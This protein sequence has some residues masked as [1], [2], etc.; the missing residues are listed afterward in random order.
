MRFNVGRF[1]LLILGILA[2]N[3][4]VTTFLSAL[5]ATGIVILIVVCII[6]AFLFTMLNYP[7]GYRKYSLKDPQFHRAFV[8]EAIFLIVLNLIFNFLF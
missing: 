5:G 8:S 2:I 6:M 4:V 1:L 7:R 3:Y